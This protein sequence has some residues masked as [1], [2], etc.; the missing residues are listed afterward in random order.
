MKLSL[1]NNIRV[2][3]KSF[4]ISTSK[5]FIVKLLGDNTLQTQK[6]ENRVKEVKGGIQWTNRQYNNRYFNNQ[7]QSKFSKNIIKIIKNLHFLNS[8]I[9]KYAGKVIELCVHYLLTTLSLCATPQLSTHSQDYTIRNS[10]LFLKKRRWRRWRRWCDVFSA[11]PLSSHKKSYA[12]T[13][14]ACQTGDYFLHICCLASL[15]NTLHVHLLVA[16]FVTSPF[17]HLFL[18]KKKKTKMQFSPAGLARPAAQLISDTFALS[19]PLMCNAFSGIVC[20]CVWVRT[21]GSR[22]TLF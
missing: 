22:L 21:S 10:L 5:I 9:S 13:H 8:I 6:S 19:Y 7:Q 14:F 2:R 3:S 11:P 15:L 20:V 18:E 12:G 16:V 17:L 4:K 1:V